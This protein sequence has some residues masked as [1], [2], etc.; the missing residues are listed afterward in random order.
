[1]RWRCVN[2]LPSFPWKISRCATLDAWSS[3][4]TSFPQ[5]MAAQDKKTKFFS[6]GN[7]DWKICS[8]DTRNILRTMTTMEREKCLLGFFFWYQRH[9]FN[10]GNVRRLRVDHSAPQTP[11]H[12]FAVKRVNDFPLT[13]YYSNCDVLTCWGVLTINGRS[14]WKRNLLK[15]VSIMQIFEGW[16]SFLGKDHQMFVSFLH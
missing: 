4:F 14:S 10:E 8:T 13:G 3:D 5:G 9:V 7:W 1:M 6:L 16:K 15:T 11:H 12:A 2:L